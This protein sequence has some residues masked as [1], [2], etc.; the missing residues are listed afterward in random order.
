MSTPVV[1]IFV[2]HSLDCPYKGDEFNK[3][4]RCAKHLRW[5]HNGK[6]HR[7]SAKAHTWAEAEVA[8]RRVEERFKPANERTKSAIEH[9]TIQQAIDLFV[10]L[11][12]S[13][14]LDPNVLK[15][16]IRELG[17]LCQFM[18]KRMAFHVADISLENL[19]EYR[20]KWTE[21]YPSSTTRQKVQERLKT[22]LG[23]CYDA[24]W[25]DRVPKLS[26]IH[27]DEPPTLPLTDQEY[28]KLLRIARTNFSRRRRK[29][30]MHSSSS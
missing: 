11:K 24:Q 14:G 22:F 12:T 13:E 7:H 3:R 4:C 17:R 28:E 15:K 27:V 21:Q 30:S 23:Y 6:Q 1:T 25:L 2:R 10:S 18:D 5:S 9:K 26:A 20:G 29:K 8:K 19:T 16:Y